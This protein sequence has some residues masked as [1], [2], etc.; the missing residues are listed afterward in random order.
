MALIDSRFELGAGGVLEE[1]TIVRVYDE[2]GGTWSQLGNVV[3]VDSASSLS[4]TGNRLAVGSLDAA[5]GVSVYELQN[6]VWNK[7]GNTIE[8]EGWSVELAQ[9]GNVIVVDNSEIVQLYQLNGDSWVPRGD[10]IETSAQRTNQGKAYSRMD[11]DETGTS[12]LVERS[13]LEF[14]DDLA[15]FYGNSLDLESDPPDT[16][17]SI[18]LDSKV[19]TIAQ[20]Q[21]NV[22][23]LSGN[24]KVTIFRFN[25]A[26][27][28]Q[29]DV[30]EGDVEN[31]RFGWSHALSGDG[32]RIVIM[33][34]P[35]AGGENKAVVYS[36]R[37]SSW[38]LL[39]E[40]VPLAL[41][42]GSVSISNDGNRVA[43]GGEGIVAFY[44]LVGA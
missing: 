18:S 24:G 2:N 6:N 4:L 3:D 26:K 42:D 43:V 35:T 20:P 39:P 27:W 10:E 41:A 7:V 38:V 15:F 25:G 33:N 14:S 32:K 8:T 31:G 12:V 44:D 40:D 5:T 28:N 11:V 17:V 13:V 9:N 23:G 19:V 1:S 34:N 37:G 30:I 36:L 21:S 16:P 29:A 22:N